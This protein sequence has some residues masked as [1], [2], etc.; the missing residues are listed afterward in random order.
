[1]LP[2]GNTPT[3]KEEACTVQTVSLQTMV[4]STILLYESKKDELP[5]AASPAMQNTTDAVQ[6][7]HQGTALQM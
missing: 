4:E 3:K 2:D 7:L 5:K 6:N 1:M